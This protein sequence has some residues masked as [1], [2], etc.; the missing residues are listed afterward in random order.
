MT[1]SQDLSRYA[2]IAWLIP[3]F[4][5][6][7]FVFSRSDLGMATDWFVAEGGHILVWWLIVTLAGLGVLPLVMRLLPSLADKGY[8]LARLTGMLLI[9]AVFWFLTSLGLLQNSPG[10]V[11]TAWIIVLLASVWAWVAWDNRPTGQ[12]WRIWLKEHWPYL[13]VYEILF[14]VALFTWSYIRAHN[15]ELVT[16]E[17]PMEMAFVNGI[18]NS[19]SFPPKDPWL[20]GYGISYYYL[21]YV[22]MATL[23]DL[24]NVPTTFAFNLMGALIF[25]LTATGALSIGYNLVRSVDGLKRWRVGGR[26]SGIG[27]GLLA[28][29]FIVLAGNLG[30]ALVELPIQ[31]Y[32]SDVPIVDEIV[33]DDYFQFWDVDERTGPFYERIIN[34][35]GTISYYLLD[36]DETV[37]SLPAGY[38][39]MPD[40]DLDGVPNWDDDPPEDDDF[41]HWWWFRHSRLIHDRN[42]AEESIGYQP[43]AEFPQFS[44]LLADSHPHVLAL[45]FTLLMIG[46]A[47]ALVLRPAPLQPWE[48]FVYGI[49]AGGMI[50]LNA[51]DAAYV[52]ILVAAEMVRRLIHNGTGH[53]SGLE[54][55]WAVITLRKRAENNLYLIGV[56]WLALFALIVW[57]GV[58]D[59]NLFIPLDIVFQALFALLLAGPVTLLVNWLMMDTDWSAVIRFGI[60]LVLCFGVFYFPW[61]DSFESQANGFYPN[62]IFPTRSQ[63]FFLQFGIFILLLTPFVIWQAWQARYRLSFWAVATIV[64][65]G[66]ILLVSVPVLSAFVI[67]QECPLSE[68]TSSAGVTSE[69][70]WACLAR[71]PLY[72]EVSNAREGMMWDVLVRR[73]TALVSQVFMLIGLGLVVVRLFP[74]EPRRSDPDRA[75]YNFSPTTAAALLLIG[76]GIVAALMPDLMYLRDNFDQRMNTVFKLYYQAWTLFSIGSAYAVYAILSGIPVS[77]IQIAQQRP[78]QTLLRGAYMM[79]MLFLL[80]SGLL[81]PYFGLRQHY[82]IETDRL[83][84]RECEGEDCLAEPVPTLDGVS[85]LINAPGSDLTHPPYPQPQQAVAWQI[86]AA[87]LSVMQCL[88]EQEPYGNDAV[89]LEVSGGGYDPAMGRFSMYT[90]IP[91]LLGWDNHE[92]QWRG[93]TFAPIVYESGRLN[94]IHLVYQAPAENWETV[95]VPIL[96]KYSIDY[97]VVGLAERR[98]YDS[99]QNRIRVPGIEKFA[100]LFDPVCEAGEAENHVAVYRVSPE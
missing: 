25:T 53:V 15:P 35:D 73:S 18:R 47:V 61:I 39:A 37:A 14:I 31:G 99:D 7:A 62:I 64:L 9:T 11:T 63:Q 98:I 80:V 97:I 1:V 70:N 90:G 22:M 87:E 34:A 58:V 29:T 68:G 69:T 88:L 27:T 45:P 78:S 86:S 51:W 13:L 60:W 81:Y 92:R 24:S 77:Q 42:L 96:E 30:T 48:V 75:L 82:L 32:V 33:S 50:F 6:M 26:F 85:T 54:E 72:G 100:I 91:T 74:Q 93:D 59:L 55:L 20:S 41:G 76:A 89:L 66:L 19:V 40:R 44:F 38:V 79:G 71:G 10:A 67:E 16:T 17:K 43:I 36:E 23:A 56:V 57:R 21:G 28:A 5:F 46:L 12:E 4:G 49:L 83:N 8:G 95:V 2:W 52:V 94:D 84:L 65:A 3:I